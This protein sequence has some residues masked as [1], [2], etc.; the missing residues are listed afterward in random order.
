MMPNDPRI[1]ALSP[2]QE[3]WVSGHIMKKKKEDYE[4]ALGNVKLICSFID[5]AR[6]KQVFTEGERSESTGF[7]ADLA[8]LDPNFKAEDY[9]DVLEE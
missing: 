2:F 6:A 5:P 3:L 8:K 7:L 4:L 9:A 1:E